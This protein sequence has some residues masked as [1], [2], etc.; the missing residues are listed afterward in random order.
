MLSLLRRKARSPLIQAAVVIIILVFILWVPQMGGNGD[1]GTVATVNDQPISTREF[2]RRYNDLLGQYRDQ[3]EGAIPSEL[4]EALGLREQVLSQMVQETLLL[5]S[6][7]KTGLPVSSEELQQAVQSMGE[8]TE[9]GQFSL[10]LYRQILAASRLSVHEFEAGL[11]TDLLRRKIL[12]HLMGFAQVSDQEVRERFHRDHDQVRLSY[13]Y[14][15]ADDFRAAQDPTSEEIEA[16]FAEKD[17]RY[18]TPPQVRIDYLLFPADDTEMTIEEEDLV[19]YY[20]QN[21]DRFDTPEQRRARHILIRSRSDAPE[22]TRARQRQQAETV[23]ELAREGQ[24][25]R[26]LALLYSEDRSAE[27]G[28]DLGFFRR[29]EMLEPLEEAVFAMEPG[30]ISDIVETSLGFH[31]IKLEEIQ[32]PQTITLAEAEAEIRREILR[33]RGRQM[34]FN[35][36]NEVYESILTTGSLARGAEEGGVSLQSTGLFTPE[37]P[38]AA[39]RRHPE[40]VSSAFELNRGE[41]SSII[42]T[43]DGYAIIYVQEREEPQVP[44]LAEVLDRVRADLIEEQAA[45]AARR[46]AEELLA[47]LQE[48][49]DLQHL[50]AA[51]GYRVRESAWFSQ[52]TAAATDLPAR[53]AR[54]GLTLTKENPVPGTV[55]SANDRF[56]VIKLQQRRTADEEL[57]QRWAEPIENDLLMAKQEAMIDT[58][59]QHLLQEAK[60]TVSEGTLRSL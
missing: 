57:F 30:E 42:S 49:Q 11:R 6:A 50:A 32:E 2:Q 58:W 39:L 38:P 33:S 14:L 53:V 47:A 24:D 10:Q 36:A 34:A 20:E 59:I 51:E 28:G 19:A 37:Q 8:F 52:A 25:F 3:F 1:P 27:D 48:G 12:E 23:Q 5:Q 44:P 18:R 45:M 29:G 54:T 40:A 43:Q 9:N 15:R 4:I 17:H 7:R 31:V 26:Q 55:Q 35:R 13:L 46:A 56:Y 60:I 22:E 16:Y 41:L 21:R